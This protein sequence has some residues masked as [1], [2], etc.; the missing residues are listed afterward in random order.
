MRSCGGAS[1]IEVFWP[2]TMLLER[3]RACILILQL[4]FDEA[5]LSEPC[6]GTDSW[7][8]CKFMRESAITCRYGVSG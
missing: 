6:F 3:G 4:F 5:H 7:F 8:R 1:R 2:A